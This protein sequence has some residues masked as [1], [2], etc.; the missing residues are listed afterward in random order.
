[1]HVE[2]DGLPGHD[3]VVAQMME[4]GDAARFAASVALNAPIVFGGQPAT[5]VTGRMELRARVGGRDVLHEYLIHNNRL[6]EDVA[7]PGV[8]YQFGAPGLVL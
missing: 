5:I 2:A 1:V 7:S 4:G 8:F 6:I 3:G